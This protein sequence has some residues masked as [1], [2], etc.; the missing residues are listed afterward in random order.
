V[1]ALIADG[2][3]KAILDKWGVSGGAITDPVINGASG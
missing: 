3:Y 2:T 1:K